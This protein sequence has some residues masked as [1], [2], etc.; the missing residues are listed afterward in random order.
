MV[1]VRNMKYI[2]IILIICIALFGS[3]AFAADA[4]KCILPTPDGGGPTPSPPSVKGKIV[5]VAPDIVEVE[6]KL[7]AGTR[8]NVQ[9]IRIRIN[10]KTQIFTYL[11]GYV[12]HNEL[13]IGEQADV[14]YIGCSA[15]KAGSPP[16]AAVIQIDATR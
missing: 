12:A 3:I 7:S 6:K 11:G 9:R 2:Q 5:Y 14:W 8:K 16:L 10:D 15:K 1:G 4:H 13:A